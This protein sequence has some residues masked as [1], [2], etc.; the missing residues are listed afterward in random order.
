MSL[1]EDCNEG[2]CPQKDVCWEPVYSFKKDYGIQNL[3]FRN[4]ILITVISGMTLSMI[5]IGIVTVSYIMVQYNKDELDNLRKKTRLI[6]TKLSN[7]LQ[8]NEKQPELGSPDLRLMVKTLSDNYQTDINIFDVKGNL[9]NSTENA[10]FDK[11]I[12]APQ[13]DVQ[14]YLKFTS[15]LTSQVIQEERIGTLKFLS[16]YIPIRN[17]NGQV[18]GYLN[19]P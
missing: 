1:H 17:L 14:A 18:I 13:M 10:I 16:C 2:P 11:G 9:V 4:K 3:S 7:D 15:E 19:L 12:L 5:F 6:A 8:Q